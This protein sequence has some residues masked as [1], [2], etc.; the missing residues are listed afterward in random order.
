MK[1]K[2]VDI[3]A[4]RLFGDET[5]S[6]TSKHDTSLP[7][8]FVAIYA[9][10]G[11]GKTS[12]FDAMEF[13]MTGKI[14]RFD[15]NFSENAEMDRDYSGDKSFIHNKDL[16]GQNVDIRMELDD[17]DPVHRTCLPDEEYK[18]LTGEAENTFFS[19]AILSQDFFASF[20]STKDAKQRFAIFAD[21]FNETNGLLEVRNELKA[22]INILP[23]QI[24][25]L[26]RSIGAKYD[27][28]DRSIS[29]ID[30]KKLLQESI[31]ALHNIGYNISFDEV[32]PEDM[33]KSN[34]LQVSVWQD[35]CEKT[36]QK[37][38]A[39]SLKL[40]DLK[41]GSETVVSIYK[42]PDL[43]N[44]I[45]EV[46]TEL[47]LITKQLGDI[48]R[49]KELN[50]I[51]ASI[52]QKINSLEYEVN[53]LQYMMDHYDV[54]E[55]H[56]NRIHDNDAQINRDKESIEILQKDRENAVLIL[57]TIRAKKQSVQECISTLND[58]LSNLSQR[59]VAMM[60][61]KNIIEEN[62][63]EL[64]LVQSKKDDNE[65]S[66]CSLNELLGTLHGILRVLSDR[67]VDL[68]EGLYFNE[69]KVIVETTTQIASKRNTLREIITSI[70]GKNKYLDEIGQLVSNSRAMLSKL[71]GGVCPLCGFDYN[72]QEELLQSISSNTIINSSL[73]KDLQ[74]KEIL[75]NEIAEKT[76]D[77][78]KLYSELSANVEGRIIH[79]KTEHSR[80][81]DVS[82]QLSDKIKDLSSGIE[83]N[84]SILKEKYSDISVISE[85]G[86][87]N[88]LENQIAQ[89]RE[90]QQLSVAEE[91]RI[92]ERISD[93]DQRI[94]ELNQRN[95]Q[96]AKEILEMKTSRVYVLYK[97]YIDANNLTEINKDYIQ[98]QKAANSAAL[99]HQRAVLF[100]YH[101]E[102]ALLSVV[103]EQ[104]ESLVI[105][106]GNL[107]QTIGEYSSIVSK[108]R[109]SL[110]QECNIPSSPYSKTSDILLLF[111]KKINDLEKQVDALEN[112]KELLSKYSSIL[113]IVGNHYRNQHLQGEVDEMIK[114]CQEKSELLSDCKKEVT[115]I[116]NHFQEFIKEYFELDLINKLYNTI[117]PHPDYKEVRFDCNF[118]T[119]EPRL[120]VLLNNVDED[121]ESIVPNLYFSTAQINILSLCIFLAKALSA[122]DDKGNDMDCVFIDDPIQA[123]DDI[124]IL[125]VIDLL[126][127]IAFSMNKQVVLTTHDR[128]FFELLKKKVPEDIFNARYITFKERG[129]FLKS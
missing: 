9:P 35:E 20:I 93:I 59:Y 98:T 11:F 94:S 1:I 65:K 49:Y 89:H 13:C 73:E 30:I 19:E 115:C 67:K 99:S 51:I 117:D 68:S 4:F 100:E 92:Q 101:Q 43:E 44:Q 15:D 56:S 106:K 96:A 58:S 25:A 18:V 47:S 80:L 39:Q 72:S 41:Y 88:M 32:M 109:T 27:Q 46:Q 66:I 52:N 108:L 31:D 114:E 104:E 54:Y 8:N 128:N 113:N 26:Q 69:R 105:R 36:Y 91:D 38:K 79:I 23:R 121:K 28:I 6:F 55:K 70:E 77:L 103:T 97:D 122:K 45:G 119:K 33:L 116:E 62:K 14:H 74:V 57:R 37:Q 42:L 40:L 102:I 127:N 7:A 48:N 85:D 5:V 120:N 82:M 34:L 87:R 110:E 22:K 118:K 107:E 63:R 71:P 76:Q 3:K 126:R 78:E 53:N 95:D 29:E 125:S 112:K 129:K 16:P 2:K 84:T 60:N 21:K 83:L 64:T 12:F 111:E 17:R 10:N 123:M 90:E 61:V 124:N 75:E 81:K 86:M 24:G 50:T